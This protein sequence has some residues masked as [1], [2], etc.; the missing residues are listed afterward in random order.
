MARQLLDTVAEGRRRE[1]VNWTMPARANQYNFSGWKR[2]ENESERIS[3]GWLHRPWSV[4][5]GGKMF[6]HKH[7][8]T[9]AA[10]GLHLI[11]FQ[12]DR[13]GANVCFFLFAPSPPTHRLNAQNVN[14]FAMNGINRIHKRII[15]IFFILMQ[16]GWQNW[17]WRAEGWWAESIRLKL[18]WLHFEIW[19]REK[20]LVFR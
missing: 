7:N 16:I 15:T 19:L 12:T 1:R 10:R 11:P 2:N 17:G 14:K 8:K 20:N 18:R 9:A 13:F 3:H 5:N 4:H 6:S